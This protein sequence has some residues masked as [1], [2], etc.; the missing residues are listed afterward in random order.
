MG[1]VEG[2][3]F[4]VGAKGPKPRRNITEEQQALLDKE[5][6]E[7]EGLA[8]QLAQPVEPL[9]AGLPGYSFRTRPTTGP[10][11]SL[12]EARQEAASDE[13][14]ILAEQQRLQAQGLPPLATAAILSGGYL[15][16]EVV[17]ELAAGATTAVQHLIPG[18]QEIERKARELMAQG[19]DPWMAAI[20]AYKTSDLPTTGTIAELKVAGY[21]VDIALGIKGA[22]ETFT[23]PVIGPSM[24]K[25][26][27]RLA[28]KL[29]KETLAET[30]RTVGVRTI[31]KGGRPT[32]EAAVEIP[33]KLANPEGFDS[34]VS[35]V[36]HPDTWARLGRLPGFKQVMNAVTPNGLAATPVDRMVV[37]L[38]VAEYRGATRARTRMVELGAIGTEKSVFGS[39]DSLGRLISGKAKG[40]TVNDLARFPAKYRELLTDKQIDWLDKAV[41]L[42]AEITDLLRRNGIKLVMETLAAG[43]RFTS[44][45]VVK[46]GPDGMPLDL[47]V[48]SKTPG[49]KAVGAPIYT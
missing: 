49:R 10:F 22:I 35:V 38:R 24:T 34:V 3:G 19:V 17:T 5:R 1:V 33:V 27:A 26:A 18:E 41:A 6:M 31:G 13:P 15:Y 25:M 2:A 11:K 45:L 42:D 30:A 21:Q 39:A 48:I 23:D 14:Q 37:G 40:L 20:T 9:T 36:T 47:G 8:Q 28:L 29:G 12:A 46:F 16:N 32:F 44:R 4:G 7:A 43:E